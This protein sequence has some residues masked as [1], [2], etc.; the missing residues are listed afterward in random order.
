[1]WDLFFESLVTCYIRHFWYTFLL[2]W[3]KINQDELVLLELD[4]D[5]MVGYG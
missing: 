1:M 2:K 4:I 5:G 3:V